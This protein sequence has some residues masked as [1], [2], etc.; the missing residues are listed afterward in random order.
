MPA[1]TKT[2]CFV[3]ESSSHWVALGKMETDLDDF[4]TQHG[5]ESDSLD[6]TQER[7]L[8]QERRDR[9]A[10]PS[11][12][13]DALMS[14]HDAGEGV[15]AERPQDVSQPI[16]AAVPTIDSHEGIPTLAG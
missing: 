13:W 8:S 16:L 6:W 10:V 14:S 11:E 15:L 2:Y 4:L 5:S 7:K 3:I 12:S 1:L 9:Y